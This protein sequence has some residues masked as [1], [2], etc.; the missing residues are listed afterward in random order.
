M[1]NLIIAGLLTY[2]Y[3]NVCVIKDK[4]VTFIF[5]L[6]V[7]AVLFELDAFFKGFRHEKQV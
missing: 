6:F 5:F 1:K 4:L 2:N 3:Y 7:A